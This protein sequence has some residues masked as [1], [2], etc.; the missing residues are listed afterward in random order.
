MR[1]GEPG[2]LT[3]EVSPIVMRAVMRRRYFCIRESY[4]ALSIVG[5]FLRIQ[6]LF[7]TLPFPVFWFL[8]HSIRPNLPDLARL[9]TISCECSTEATPRIDTD[10][11]GPD[12]QSLCRPVSV[13]D[14]LGPRIALIPW[15]PIDESDHSC[16]FFWGF[17]TRV[18][19]ESTMYEDELISLD[20]VRE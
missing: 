13:D 5:L 9:Q 18:W 16:Y 14:R 20:D 8:V 1:Y 12:A 6:L 17:D 15:S 7:I 4:G 3:S 11:I 19:M 10:R 2:I